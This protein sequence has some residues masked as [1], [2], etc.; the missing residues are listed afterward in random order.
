MRRAGPRARRWSRRGRIV[1]IFAGV[2]LG[3]LRRLWRTPDRREEQLSSDSARRWATV[4]SRCTLAW[5]VLDAEGA[6]V[7]VRVV[8]LSFLTLVF[9]WVFV[10]LDA[11][12]DDIE[13]AYKG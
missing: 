11:R 7:A 2:I 9:A 4:S 3:M 8:A 6:P 5:L 12:R 10:H 13:I 1:S